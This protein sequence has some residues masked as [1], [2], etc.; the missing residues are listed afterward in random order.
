M[1]CTTEASTCDQIGRRK[2]GHPL[3]PPLD[4]VSRGYLYLS[5]FK[6]YN[7]SVAPAKS[8][9]VSFKELGKKLMANDVTF[10]NNKKLTQADLRTIHKLL[11][12]HYPEFAEQ[13]EDWAKANEPNPHIWLIIEEVID[14]INSLEPSVPVPKPEVAYRTK[15]VRKVPLSR[16]DKEDMSF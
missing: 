14:L 16:H 9:T 11:T 6:P 15:P 13:A 2:N 12:W 7:S 4:G 3:K 1:K 8:K 5:S 10:A